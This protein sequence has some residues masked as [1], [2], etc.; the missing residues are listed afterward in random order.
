VVRVTE[1]TGTPF[2]CA[3][4]EI[5]EEDWPATEL[6]RAGAVSDGREA[7]LG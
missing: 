1:P 7:W 4:F 5:V 2:D 6:E 3:T